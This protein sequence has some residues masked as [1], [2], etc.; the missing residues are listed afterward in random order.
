MLQ[1]WYPA[2]M[3][4]RRRLYF[5]ER[6]N[7]WLGL[8]GNNELSRDALVPHHRGRCLSKACRIRQGV[9]KDWSKTTGVIVEGLIKLV[10]MGEA[11]GK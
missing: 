2:V 3:D 5:R 10:A 6:G 7:L 8:E 9:S 1:L 11:G 4:Y